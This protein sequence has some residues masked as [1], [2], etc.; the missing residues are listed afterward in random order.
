MSNLSAK[1]RSGWRK[2]KR[3]SSNL[4][5]RSKRYGKRERIKTETETREEE[6][7]RATDCWREHR[8][9]DIECRIAGNRHARSV[10]TAAIAAGI[11]AAAHVVHA[12]H[13]V[14]AVN[15]YYWLYSGQR[16]VFACDLRRSVGVLNIST[17]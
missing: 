3:F 1:M 12:A 16:A 13:I 17:P 15:A 6:R 10:S 2:K 14:V 4:S 7:C 9:G 5:K 11:I 8:T